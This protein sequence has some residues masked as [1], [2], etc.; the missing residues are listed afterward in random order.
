MYVVRP[1]KLYSRNHIIYV[2][3][4]ALLFEAGGEEENKEEKINK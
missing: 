3:Q 1:T 2:L 4:L